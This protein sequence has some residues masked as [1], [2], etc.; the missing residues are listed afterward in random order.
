[1]SGLFARKLPGLMKVDEMNK[2]YGNAKKVV[3]IQL[4]KESWKE[5]GIGD[6]K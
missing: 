5:F 2:L 6:V 1:M 3:K 4:P